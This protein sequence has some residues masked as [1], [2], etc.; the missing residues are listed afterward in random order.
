MRT[1]SQKTVVQ[2][3]KERLA[4][5]A[6]PRHW[7]LSD[8]EIEN[9]GI[10]VE[11]LWHHP[12]Q[13]H[14]LIRLKPVS[15]GEF[16]FY[17]PLYL[18]P[19]R[20]RELEGEVSF[21]IAGGAWFAY[22]PLLLPS[23]LMT[24]LKNAGVGNA[25]RFRLDPPPTG[26]FA[27]AS[28][29]PLFK[30]DGCRV[31]PLLARG[32]EPT[33]N[34]LYLLDVPGVGAGQS[35]VAKRYLPR[36]DPERGN[37]EWKLATAL[38]SELVPR[39][40]GRLLDTRTNNTLVG[41][42]EYVPGAEVGLVLWKLYGL[43]GVVPTASV[44]ARVRVVFAKGLRTLASFYLQLSNRFRTGIARGEVDEGLF[45]RAEEDVRLL[46][47][48]RLNVRAYHTIISGLVAHLEG[49]DSVFHGPRAIHGDLMWRQIIWRMGPERGKDFDPMALPLEPPEE[50][51]G[52][53]T[54]MDAES[55]RTGYLEEDLAG[56][57][58]ANNLMLALQERDRFAPVVFAALWHAACQ[59]NDWDEAQASRGIRS[60]LTLIRLRHLHD[61]AY[62]ARAKGENPAK[63]AEYER[64]VQISLGLA[65]LV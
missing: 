57:G 54:I 10:E 61:A 53:L 46:R 8:A 37:R 59:A 34:Y 44:L 45:R 20:L 14:L 11:T 24:L 55:W 39:P 13:S 12:P 17:L 40:V 28:D 27:A 6:D 52:R 65:G 22:D 58:A 41:F 38:S 7:R 51:P 60:L 1:L 32:E 29:N 2:V 26:P 18:A 19:K 25:G 49:G 62:Y 3:V 30:P 35:L 47:G 4:L 64:Y 36:D 50:M 56:L 16:T 21:P 43:L 15:G 42:Y 48:Y 5:V 31:K 23:A 9:A 63:T 33:T